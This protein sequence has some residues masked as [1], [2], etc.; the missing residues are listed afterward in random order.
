MVIASGTPVPLVFILRKQ[1][2]IN[3]FAA[4]YS[5]GDSVIA[6]TKGAVELLNRDELQAV[7]A[8]E[9]SHIVNGDIRLNLHMACLLHGLSF[10]STV[11]RFVTQGRHIAPVAVGIVVQIAGYIG[12]SFGKLIRLA[13]SRQREFLADVAAVQFT[14]NPGGVVLAFKKIGGLKGRSYIDHPARESVSLFFS[15]PRALQHGLPFFERILHLSSAFTC[16]NRS[17]MACSRRSQPWR[18]RM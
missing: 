15:N 3:A 5:R 16:S 11:G 9:F 17:L 12:M 10:V 7:V 13:V 6:V 4:G 18:R 8:H 1:R 2:G 14:R